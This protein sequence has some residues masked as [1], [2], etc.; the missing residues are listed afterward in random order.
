MNMCAWVYFICHFPHRL[1]LSLRGS[2]KDFTKPLEQV[3]VS[4]FYLYKKSS[5]K[6][7][8]LKLLASALKEIYVF[9]NNSTCPEKASGT[10]WID[11]KMKAMGKLNGEFGVNAAHLG[12]VFA[13]TMKQ[14]D[15]IT[16]Q[17]K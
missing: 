12:N 16:L 17:G 9:E 15:R 6:L 8:E 5:K 10:R 7:H 14:C 4:L 3:L 1:E 2:L 13:D 11:N